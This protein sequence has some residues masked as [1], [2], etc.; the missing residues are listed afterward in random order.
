M[1]ED[2]IAG[3]KL[4]L[5]RWFPQY[6]VRPL[7]EDDLPAMVR[8]GESNP[9][10]YEHSSSANTVDEHRADLTAAP[11]GIPPE[12][13]HYVGFFDGDALIAALDLIDGYPDRET[14]FLGFF[15]VA[16]ERSGQ[17][18][19]SAIIAELCACL[20][21]VGFRRVRLAIDRTNP[22]S[23]HFWRKQGFAV[24][25]EVDRGRDVVYL[26]EKTL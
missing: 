1:S 21:R 8:L 13:K 12:R 22:Q 15:I 10:F 5:A 2:H 6:D 4:N 26:A 9:L 23:N 7:G 14:A 24:L 16:G 25:R 20:K 19:G 11:P 18:L 17:G 3:H